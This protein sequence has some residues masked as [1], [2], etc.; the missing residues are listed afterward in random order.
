MDRHLL[1]SLA[2]GASRVGDRMPA[3][4]AENFAAKRQMVPRRGVK[5]LSQ[6]M[7]RHP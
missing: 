5:I 6:A 7:P 2:V 4:A 1:G 3:I